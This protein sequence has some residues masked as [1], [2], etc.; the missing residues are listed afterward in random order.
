MANIN[1]GSERWLQK[2]EGLQLLVLC[3]PFGQSLQPLP[4]EHVVMNSLP[5]VQIF[6]RIFFLSQ[7]RVQTD[8]QIR[9]MGAQV[10]AGGPSTVEAGEGPKAKGWG[11]CEE[12]QWGGGGGGGQ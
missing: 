7:V 1:T 3:Q 12:G 6:F 4:L 2:L 5:K 10:P 11:W 8:P 9:S